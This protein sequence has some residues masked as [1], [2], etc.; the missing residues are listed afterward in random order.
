MYKCVECGH[1]FEEGEEKRWDE[2][3]GECFGFPYYEQ[4]DGCPVCKGNFEKTVRCKL[5]NS[6]H[7]ADEL[8]S[9]VCE[10]CIEERKNDLSVCKEI[11]DGDLREIKINGLLASFFEQG[12]IEQ[13]LFDFIRIKCPDA[14]FSKYIDED[15]SWFA[16]RL[17]K[18]ESKNK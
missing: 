3:Q 2:Y 17:V 14:D 1:I 6:E 5:C 15:K 9:G 12:E 11:G 18:I 10:G 16:E 7:L 8:W 13:I 4:M